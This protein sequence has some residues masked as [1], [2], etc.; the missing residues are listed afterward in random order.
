MSRMTEIR[1]TVTESTPVL[2]VVGAT[3]VVVERVRATTTTAVARAEKVQ[4]ELEDALT[5]YQTELRKG[6][7]VAQAE[8]GKTVAAYQVGSRPA[9]RAGQ[10]QRERQGAVHQVPVAV[11]QAPALAVARA[12][13]VAGQVETGYAGL[14]ER[15]KVLVERVRRQ[16]PTQD[17]S[18]RARPR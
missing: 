13:E 5:T 9:A 2:V 4:A 12:L 14:A 8:V 15:G 1:K 18:S 6:L 17:S 11:Q 7:Q 3:D 16:K 10:G